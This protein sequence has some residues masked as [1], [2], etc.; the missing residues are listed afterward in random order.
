[1]GK[2]FFQRQAAGR[3]PPL[4]QHFLRDSVASARIVEA[5]GAPARAAVVEIGPGKGVLT[6]LLACRSESL[7][8][9]EIDRRLAV[10]LEEEFTGNPAVEIVCGDFLQMDLDA[11]AAK[12]RQSLRVT[13]NLPYYITSDILLHLFRHSG[14]VDRAVLMMQR[15]VAERLTASPGVREYGAL[16]AL[17]A[18]HASVEFLF[19][20]PPEAFSPPPAVQSSVVRLV[21][22]SRFEE[23]HVDREGFPKFLHQ[24]FAQKRKTLANNLLAAGFEPGPVRKCME[25]SGLD[26]MVRAE[27][28]PIET[29]AELYLVLQ[30]RL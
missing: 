10:A 24:I 30:E 23:L 19:G 4:G 28:L 22:H 29:A 16:T 2:T 17:T 5:L 8:A 20:L 13:G 1:M 6:R 18:M 9:V 26:P 27:S 11:L 12:K 7:T 3:K 25:R 21:M 14:A 15:E